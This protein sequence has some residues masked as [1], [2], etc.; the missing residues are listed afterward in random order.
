[1]FLKAKEKAITHYK[2][3]LEINPKDES[4]IRNW[5]VYINQ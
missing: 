3:S 5:V 1:M 4:T 2:K